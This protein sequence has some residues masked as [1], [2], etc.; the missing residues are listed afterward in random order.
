MNQA[1]STVRELALLNQL[2]SVQVLQQ[3]EQ[4]ELLYRQVRTLGGMAVSL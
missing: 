1:E 3:G 2:F 4:I